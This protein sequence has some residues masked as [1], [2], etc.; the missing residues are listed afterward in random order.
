MRWALNHM[1]WVID[2]NDVVHWTRSAHLH[3]F[4]NVCVMG[5]ILME[6]LQKIYPASAVP[7][8]RMYI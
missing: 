3:Y 2:N 8:K 1:L 6:V 5:E 4:C 7:C